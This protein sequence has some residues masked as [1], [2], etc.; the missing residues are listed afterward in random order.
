[1][2]CPSQPAVW[3]PVGEPGPAPDTDL[4]SPGA[5]TRREEGVQARARQGRGM[6]G[7]LECGLH[8]DSLA[9]LSVL[10]LSPLDAQ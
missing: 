6:E 9:L 3:E 4:A 7:G 10:L 2:T 8:S 1:M 5:L